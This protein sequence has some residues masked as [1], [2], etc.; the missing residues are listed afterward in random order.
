MQTDLKVPPYFRGDRTD[1]FIIHKWEDMMSCYP[2]RVKCD[3]ILEM[4]DLII[5]R[6]TGRARDVMK[7]SLCSR[8]LMSPSELPVAV[9]DILKCNFSE[10]SGSNMPMKNFCS[11]VL[12]T[13]GSSMDYWIR[14]NKAIDAANDCFRRRGRS[15]EDRSTEI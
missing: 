14:L 11:P 8:G 6:L 10:L 3:T 7:V 2:K 13:G 9:F 12:R 4:Q 1:A 15:V 5:S